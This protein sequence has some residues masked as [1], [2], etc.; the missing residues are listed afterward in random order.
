MLKVL[1]LV[2]I[3]VN[4]WTKVIFLSTSG[5]MPTIC[6]EFVASNALSLVQ[7]QFEKTWSTR[8]IEV[9]GELIGF[10]MYGYSNELNHY[11]ICRIMIDKKWQGKGYGRKAMKLVIEELKA[12]EGC[13]EIYLSTDPKNKNGKKL[14]E[15][16][17]FKFSNRYVDE[18]ELYCYEL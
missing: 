11:E 10:T 5:E 6:E 2:E 1:K 12:I 8:A 7:A 4:N 17:G 14:Y 13:N 9:N 16:L 3:N 15:S 18:E